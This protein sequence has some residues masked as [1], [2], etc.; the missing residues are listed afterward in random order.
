MQT[1]FALLALCDGKPL[2]T[3]LRHLNA[4]ATLMLGMC[5]TWPNLN[6]SMLDHTLRWTYIDGLAQD[7]SNSIANALGLLQSSAKQWLG[8]CCSFDI[9]DISDD[10]PRDCA[11]LWIMKQ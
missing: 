10:M 4:D 11:A 9:I 2:V 8:F 3:D 1:L 5:F 6:A 7:C